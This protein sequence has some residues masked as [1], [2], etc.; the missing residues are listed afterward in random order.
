MTR[1]DEVY[2]VDNN[3]M[4]AILKRLKSIESFKYCGNYKDWELDGIN[5]DIEYISYSF[6][7]D[8]YYAFDVD[9]YEK[10]L[11]VRIYVSIHYDG[12]SMYSA[13]KI[14]LEVKNYFFKLF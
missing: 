10:D 14:A 2:N 7:K 6:I 5:K 12:E 3:T 13:D 1:F 9:I 4:N 8:D 11:K